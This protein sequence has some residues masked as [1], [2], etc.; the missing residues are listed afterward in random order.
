MAVMIKVA[1]MGQQAAAEKAKET[2]KELLMSTV[3]GGVGAVIMWQLLTIWPSLIAYVLFTALGGL[4]MGR[5]IFEGK[6]MH[7]GA[8]VWSYAYLTMLVIIAPSLMGNPG[9]DSASVR[10]YDRLAMM[11]MATL[12]ATA[13]VSV[14]DAFWRS[15]APRTVVE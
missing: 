1:S 12:Y 15:K 9:S 4:I 3:I 11:G 10:F 8:E 5:K 13:A 14:F 7:R 2:G 6:G